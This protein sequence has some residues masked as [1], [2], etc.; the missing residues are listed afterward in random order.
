MGSRNC[1]VLVWWPD[2]RLF[3]SLL[4]GE[5]E[6]VG[7]MWKACG[8]V[9]KLFS[10]LHLFPYLFLH[11]FAGVMSLWMGEVFQ[12]LELE[13]SFEEWRAGTVG[14]SLELAF[15]AVDLLVSATQNS[16]WCKSTRTA[17]VFLWPRTV[18]NACAVP[19][20]LFISTRSRSVNVHTQDRAVQ[21][22]QR[23][24]THSGVHI[25]QRLAWRF[26]LLIS[27]S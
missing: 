10:F 21:R 14:W 12:R 26:Q 3:P 2:A 22:V 9:T 11:S 6:L 16:P 13:F 8:G 15:S 23:I 18:E 24:T 1:W 7:R 25:R 5:C 20:V 27:P 17:R 19:S 4:F